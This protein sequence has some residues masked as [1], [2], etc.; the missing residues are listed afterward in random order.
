MMDWRAIKN[1]TL[2]ALAE[3]HFD[4]FI[5]IDIVRLVPQILAAMDEADKGRSLAID[6]YVG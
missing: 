1:G 4:V 3:K 2:L 6:G 5:S